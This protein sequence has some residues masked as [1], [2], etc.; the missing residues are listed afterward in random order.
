MCMYVCVCV[1]LMWWDYHIILLWISRHPLHAIAL[2]I[3]SQ[4]SGEGLSSARLRTIEHHNVPALECHEERNVNVNRMDGPRNSVRVLLISLHEVLVFI[5]FYCLNEWQTFTEDHRFTYSFL[6]L[7]N[8]AGFSHGC[9]PGGETGRE[10]KR[11]EKEREENAEAVHWSSNMPVAAG[12]SLT[13]REFP[14]VVPTLL[15]PPERQLKN[16]S[17]VSFSSGKLQPA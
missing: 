3:F 6:H 4:L 10:R 9:H 7:L 2:G 12:S 8:E 17:S 16:C 1:C 5:P 13:L 11:K 15:G 14:V